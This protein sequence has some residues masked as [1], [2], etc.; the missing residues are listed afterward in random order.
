LR[1][2]ALNGEPGELIHAVKLAHL[3]VGHE[4]DSRIVGY[5]FDEVARHRCRK[6]AATDE[7]HHASCVAGEKERRLAGRVT[8]ADDGDRLLPAR[9][10]LNLRRGEIDTEPAQLVEPTDVEAAVPRAGCNH[11]RAGCDVDAFG[12][13]DADEPFLDTQAK[14]V[15]RRDDRHAELACLDESAGR[16]LSA[17]DARRKTRIV[18]D[19]C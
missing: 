13:T 15:E 11:H 4:R 8:A 3:C 16:E 10:R 2:A 9:F 12:A 7:Q 18:L 17:R 5:P 14:G 1:T 19:P 6:R